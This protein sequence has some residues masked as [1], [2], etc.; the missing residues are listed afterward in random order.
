MN[1]KKILIIGS[2]VAILLS[3]AVIVY[4]ATKS[5]N[6]PKDN[7]IEGINLPSNKDILKDATVN[8]LK[9]SKVSVVT[10]DNISTYKATVSNETSASIKINKLY[11]IFY[12]GDAQRKVLALSETNLA[13]NKKTYINIT[14]ENDL[15]KVTK[16]EYVIE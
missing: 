4:A 1:K 9:I 7:Y 12:E 8:N 16:I 3:I 10:R 2:I 14:S 15:T 5:N 11:V 6:D 13:P